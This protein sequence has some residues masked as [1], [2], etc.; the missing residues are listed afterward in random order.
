MVRERDKASLH[1][2]Q[3]V[4]PFVISPLPRRLALEHFALREELIQARQKIAELENKLAG[5]EVMVVRDITMEEAKEEIRQLLKEGDTFYFSD[6]A[7]KLR[8]DLEIVVDICRELQG[9]RE[10]EVDEEALTRT[11]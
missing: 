11:K 6:I 1:T 4:S 10:I 9:D 3:S 2:A 7:D 5:E 8:I